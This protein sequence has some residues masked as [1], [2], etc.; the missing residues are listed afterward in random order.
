M[1]FPWA[2]CSPKGMRAKLGVLV[3][4]EGRK[5]RIGLVK[6]EGVGRDGQRSTYHHMGEAC[7]TENCLKTFSCQVG[8]NP[9]KQICS[10]TERWMGG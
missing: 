7:Q 5:D 9:I 3:V 8:K 6:G 4:G 2:V 10:K 1:K